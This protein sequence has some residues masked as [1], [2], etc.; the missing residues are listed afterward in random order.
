MDTPKPKPKR[1][2]KTEEQK[3]RHAQRQAETRARIAEEGKVRFVCAQCGGVFA[4]PDG[5]SAE[6]AGK[7]YRSFVRLG[8]RIVC[9]VCAADR[10]K[11]RHDVWGI[12][13]DAIQ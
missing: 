8:G 6:N 13:P 1:K 3:R 5:L 10:F 11:R 2:P 4:V 9:E 7:R 12:L